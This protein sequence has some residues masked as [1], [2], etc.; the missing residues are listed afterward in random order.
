MRRP[1]CLTK[2][3]QA[4]GVGGPQHAAVFSARARCERP[5][6]RFQWAGLRTEPIRPTRALCGQRDVSCD[7]STEASEPRVSPLGEKQNLVLDPPPRTVGTV[8]ELGP[9]RSAVIRQPAQPAILASLSTT[10]YRRRND[11]AAAGIRRTRPITGRLQ[12]RLNENGDVGGP[13]GCA[14]LIHPA[15][16]AARSTARES[17]PLPGLQTQISCSQ[18]AICHASSLTRQGSCRCRSIS[19]G[20]QINSIPQGRLLLTLWQSRTFLVYLL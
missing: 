3:L 5:A 8:T 1:K 4:H 18:A 19:I 16:A 9:S 13:V 15:G 14:Q 7:W 10:G 6:V 11:D 12:L 2:W 20:V 17:G